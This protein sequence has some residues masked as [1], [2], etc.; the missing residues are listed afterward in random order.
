M[1]GLLGDVMLGRGVA[2]RFEQAPVQRLWSDEVIELAR[3]A[4]RSLQPRV[5]HLPARRPHQ[6][7]AG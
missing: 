5:L 4:T 6:P 7:G 2:S 3:R 1:I